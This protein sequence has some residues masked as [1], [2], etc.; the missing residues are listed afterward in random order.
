MKRYAVLV[1]CAVIAFLV[2]T[3]CGGGEDTLTDIINFIDGI[4]ATAR[5]IRDIRDIWEGF[6]A[7]TLEEAAEIHADRAV[8]DVGIEIAA[9]DT[10]ALA[11]NAELEIA[12]IAG[13]SVSAAAVEHVA[14]E[15]AIVDAMAREEEILLEFLHEQGFG[16]DYCCTSR[17]DCRMGIP[18]APL[19]EP[20]QCIVDNETA[21]GLTCEG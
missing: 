20:C 19:D 12:S 9:L 3:G 11:E 16:G 18:G 1:A 21:D 10:T 15:I 4:G 8:E 7:D 6:E 2:V 5:N 14:A 13:A 17:G